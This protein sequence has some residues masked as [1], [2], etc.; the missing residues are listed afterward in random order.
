MKK[1]CPY[2]QRSFHPHPRVGTRQKTCGKPSCKK[3]GKAKNNARWRRNNPDYY[4]DDYAR[5]KEWLAHHPHYL[6]S[7]RQNHPEYVQRDREA[8]RF[9]YRKKKIRVDI[10]AQIQNQMPK[11]TEQLWNRPFV[12]IQASIQ[13]QPLEMTFLFGAFP[14]FDIQAQMDNSAGLRENGPILSRR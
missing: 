1:L 3:A 6:K 12:D 8:R 4:R 2:C 5:V 11:I 14:A 9:R 10:Q 13:T 7:Y